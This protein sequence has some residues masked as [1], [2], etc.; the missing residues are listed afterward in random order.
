MLKQVKFYNLSDISGYSVDKSIIYFL[1]TGFSYL[2]GLF[3][4]VK[5]VPEFFYPGKFD[6]WVDNLY[7]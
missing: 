2:F 5:R 6:I 7:F 3:I 4:Y 1:L